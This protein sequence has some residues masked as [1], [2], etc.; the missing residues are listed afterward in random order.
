MTRVMRDMVSLAGLARLAG[1]P[2]RDAKRAVEKARVPVVMVIDAIELL[3]GPDARR[4]V[5]VY[6]GKRD[7]TVAEPMPEREA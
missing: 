3:P 7:E 5:E 2:R 6:V 1:I 4:A